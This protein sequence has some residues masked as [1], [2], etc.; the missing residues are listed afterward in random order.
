MQVQEILII[1]NGSESYGV[2]T[3]DINQISRVPI[4]MPLPL[5]P[6]GIRGLCSISGSVVSMVDMNLLLDMPCVNYESSQTRLLSLNE[7]YSSNALL[8]SEVYNTLEIQESK[9]EYI[10]K[11]DDPVIAIYKY[12]DSLIQILSLELLF[13]KINKVVIEGKEVKNGKSKVEDIKEEESNRFL[14]FHMDKEKFALKIDYLQEII[15]TDREFT[16]VI[17]STD[18]TIGLITLRD[19]LLLVVDLRVYYGFDANR[20]DK[21][22]ILIASYKDKRVGLLIDSIV[23]IKNIVTSK[24]EYMKNDSENVGISGVI[25]DDDYLISFL[26]DDILKRI[27]KEN[28]TFIDSN[29]KYEEVSVNLENSMEVIVFKLSDKEYSFEVDSVDEIIDIE[30]STEI[31]YSNS[32]VDGIIN[33]RGQIVTIISLF[34]KLKIPTDIRVDSKIIICNVDGHRIGFIV[35]SVSDILTVLEENIKVAED[36]FFTNILYLDNGKRL[37]LSMD[38]NKIINSKE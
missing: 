11:K 26:D 6:S 18:E 9:I 16:E 28:E 27:L 19:E 7:K 31:A 17:G 20:H 30:S 25:H 10:D 2:S 3:H 33:I 38:I 36:D 12:K 13:S 24:V 5:R 22:R 8:V 21:N 23:D 32:I 37:V 14:V 29:S 35:D 4:L 34:K 15:L 1:K